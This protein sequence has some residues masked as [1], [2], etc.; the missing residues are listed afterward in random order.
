MTNFFSNKIKK[1]TND[2]ALIIKL[3]CNGICFRK[4]FYKDSKKKKCRESVLND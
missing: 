1:K 3:D 2:F 4:K